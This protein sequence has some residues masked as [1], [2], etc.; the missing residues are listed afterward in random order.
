MAAGEHTEKSSQRLSSFEELCGRN[1]VVLL[2][3]HGHVGE[4]F[5]E[6]VKEGP[7]WWVGL[8]SRHIYVCTVNWV[9]ISRDS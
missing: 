4:G 8:C 9:R 1:C 2:L 7:S 6:R 5:L 3:V